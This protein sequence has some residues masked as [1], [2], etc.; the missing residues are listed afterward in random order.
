MIEMN[1]FLNEDDTEVALEFPEPT[2]TLTAKQL[3]GF[4]EVLV[5]VRSRMKPPMVETA[6]VLN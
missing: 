5:D 3:E 1:A 6:T 2:L 4:I